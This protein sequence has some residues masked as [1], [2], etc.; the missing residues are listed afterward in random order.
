MT[1]CEHTGGV[2][3][4]SDAAEERAAARLALAA[5]L[6]P[7][8]LQDFVGQAEIVGRL[9]ARPG[10][11]RG[12][13]R[14][15]RLLRAAGKRKT[16]LARI[17]AGATGATFEELSA[18]S[19]SVADVRSGAG[20]RR[21]G[22]AP[23]DGARSSSST[24]STASTRRSRTPSCPRSSPAPDPDRRDDREPVLRGQLALLS[25]TQVY[26]LQLLARDEV[27]VI[28]RRGAESLGADV[29]DELAEL[30]SVKA[31]GD[32]FGA[33][34]PRAGLVDG[35]VGGSDSGGAARRGRRTASGRWSTTRA[36]RALRLHLGVH[37]VDPRLRP[38][39][40]AL[41]PRGDAGRG[42]GPRFIARRLIV[43]ASEDV[44]MADSRALLVATA[45]R[46][47]ARGAAGGAAQP[48]PRDHLPGDRAEV[49]C[50]GEGDRRRPPR[51][52]RAGAARRPSRS[53]TPA[54]AARRSSATARATSTAGRPGRLRRRLPPGVASAAGATRAPGREARPPPC[55]VPGT[56]PWRD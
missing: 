18:V 38:R 22:S 36:G 44:G 15:S 19:A 4:L 41:L 31:G 42:R 7:E 20:A 21:S 17:I 34:R 48:R 16:T 29:P 47:G 33:E 8:R 24:R 6:R 28:V 10:D 9:G 3:D 30:I 12:P 50:R 46:R 14:V 39:R 27:A 43:H 49:E 32:A 5:R 40:G 56:W 53:G 2:S 52:A 54:T 45:A 37:Q 25:R 55:P 26:E 23:R 35:A 51:R 11:R 13:G 1:G